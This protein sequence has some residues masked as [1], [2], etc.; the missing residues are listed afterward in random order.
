MLIKL[1]EVAT[2]C[3]FTIPGA[4]RFQVHYILKVFTGLDATFI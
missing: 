4:N 2:T 3:G 1:S